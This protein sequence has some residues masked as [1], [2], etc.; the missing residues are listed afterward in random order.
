MSLF[1]NTLLDETN[2]QQGEHFAPTLDGAP[3]EEKERYRKLR[4][5][6]IAGKLGK[7]VEEVDVTKLVEV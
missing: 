1:N 7:P 5:R 6:Y 4:I 3:D 2:F